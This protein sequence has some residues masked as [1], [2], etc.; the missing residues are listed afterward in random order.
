MGADVVIAH[1]V[2]SDVTYRDRPAK[3]RQPRSIC[4]QKGRREESRLKLCRGSTA[5]QAGG[6]SGGQGLG[7]K[8][9]LH[10]N[11]PI[12]KRDGW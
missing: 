1:P 5:P 4:A 2:S 6:D 11:I 7:E 10:S 12:L 3:R 8:G 9:L